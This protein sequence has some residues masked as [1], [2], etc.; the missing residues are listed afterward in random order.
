MPAWYAKVA[1]RLGLLLVM[2]EGFRRPGE[3][4]ANETIT[5]ACWFTT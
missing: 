5:A 3:A 2:G 1:S 4:V